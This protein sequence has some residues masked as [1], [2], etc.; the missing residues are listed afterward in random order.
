LKKGFRVSSSLVQNGLLKKD[1]QPSTHDP[2]VICRYNGNDIYALRLELIVGFEESRQMIDMAGW[3]ERIKEKRI[4]VRGGIIIE[5][6]PWRTV[7]APGTE[8]ITTFLPFHSSVLMVLAGVF[9]Y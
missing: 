9:F 5:M 6:M 2:N 8:N 7:K 4:Q 3:L 1:L